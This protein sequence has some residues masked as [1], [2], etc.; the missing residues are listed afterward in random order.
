MKQSINI[1]DLFNPTS[2]K[3]WLFEEYKKFNMKQQTAVEWLLENIH[4]I[5]K[6]KLSVQD[7]IDKAKQMEK[8]QII[9]AYCDGDNNIG[10]EEYYNKIYN[11]ENTNGTSIS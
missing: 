4:I 2:E 5:P 9:E 1:S 8:E 3:S 7:T 10:A 6:F 11:N